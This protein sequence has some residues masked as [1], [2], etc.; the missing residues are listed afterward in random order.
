MPHRHVDTTHENGRC[1]PW[2]FAHPSVLRRIGLLLRCGD[3][4][5]NPGPRDPSARQSRLASSERKASTEKAGASRDSSQTTLP[6]SQ[7]PINR[8]ELRDMLQDLNTN[9]NYQ[10][11]ALPLANMAGGERGACPVL[12][13]SRPRPFPTVDF[14]ISRQINYGNLVKREVSPW[15]L[16]TLEETLCRYSSLLK[17]P[18]AS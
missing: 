13:Q 12:S 1:Y 10:V 9:M 16:G 18:S 14:L 15:P 5:K 8:T 6:F 4:E 7:E 17:N 11:S 3:V 2:T